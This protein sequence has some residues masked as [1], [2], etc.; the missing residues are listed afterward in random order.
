MPVEFTIE[1][2]DFTNSTVNVKKNGDLV[3]SKIGERNMRIKLEYGNNYLLSFSK[4]GYITKK[5]E[6]NTIV[7]IERGKQGF[8]PYK[9][10]VRIFKQ[11]EGVNI[12]VYNQP[13]ALIKYLAD[14]DAFNYDVDYTKSILSV[15]TDTENK[16]IT[17]AA[18]EREMQK[19]ILIKS[20]EVSSVSN[21]KRKEKV[22]IAT[23]RALAKDSSKNELQ[24]EV[25][26]ANAKDAKHKMDLLAN[27]DTHSGYLPSIGGDNPHT[28]MLNVSD[29]HLDN[30]PNNIGEDGLKDNISIVKGQDTVRFSSSKDINEL[31]IIYFKREKSSDSLFVKSG[32]SKTEA[33]KS[34]MFL[35]NAIELPNS[36]KNENSGSENKNSKNSSLNEMNRIIEKKVEANRVITTI[37]IINGVHSAEYK[38]IVYN[39]GGEFFFVNKI[40]PISS[41]LFDLYTG[42]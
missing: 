6:V 11:Y 36:L 9:I 19:R 34:S 21:I 2:G 3:L 7:P 31:P 20:T 24:T 1:N 26:I 18:E 41:H 38:H 14:L 29:E 15:L 33:R 25:N 13:V 28:S 10:G 16:L 5:I 23:S 30:K 40:E 8:E 42:K 39:W 32:I 27:E 35:S 17:K 22:E 12:V 37:R 4:P